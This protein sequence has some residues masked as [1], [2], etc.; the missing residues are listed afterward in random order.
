MDNTPS[1]VSGDPY[2]V[3]GEHRRRYVIASNCQSQADC[4]L[5]VDSFDS[6]TGKRLGSIT[7]RWNGSSYTYR[8][9]PQWFAKA[10]GSTCRTTAGDLIA[11]AY[12]T[13]EEVSVTPGQTQGG[14]IVEMT[15]TKTISGTPTAIGTAAGCDPF[16]M[17]YSVDMVS[18]G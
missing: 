13:H 14:L 17:S 12:S 2:L 3:I 15:G 8:G 5:A 18:T 7:F 10:G 4:R 16:T 1:G 6:D 9:V 11:N